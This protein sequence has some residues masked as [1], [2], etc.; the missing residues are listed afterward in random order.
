VRSDSGIQSPVNL[1][2]KR[3]G[4][5]EYSNTASVVVRGVL[6]DEYGFQPES[7]EWLVGD[8]DY[9]ERTSIDER[10][11]PKTGLR[12]KGVTSKTLGNMLVDGELDALIA[13]KPPAVYGRGN[14]IVRL[15]TDWRAVEKDYYRRSKHFPIMHVMAVRKDVLQSH[16]GVIESLME[17]FVKAKD[18]AQSR[19]STHQAH[20]VMLPW[21][22]AEH[23]ETQA[24]M[25]QDFWPYGFTENLDILD[26]QIRWSHQ[27]GLIPR[28]YETSEFF[29]TTESARFHCKER[30]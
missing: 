2:G 11:W 13:Y 30:F 18:L 6:A 1:R 14:N 20:P 8:I 28:V 21:L 5:R 22:T 27:Q 25:G 16:A 19:L 3:I 29:A 24:V 9:V 12:I 10:N 26:T 23:E 15:F 7:S 4:C 17:G